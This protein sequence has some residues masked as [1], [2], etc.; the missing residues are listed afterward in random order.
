[1]E[2]YIWEDAISDMLDDDAIS[3]AEEGFLR[4]YEE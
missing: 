1:M 4:G 2:E 3:S